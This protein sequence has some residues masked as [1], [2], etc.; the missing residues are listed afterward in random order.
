[1]G[2]TGGAWRAAGEWGTEGGADRGCEEV[3]GYLTFGV[4]P[5]QKS[6]N[7]HRH[8][9][10]LPVERSASRGLTDYSQVDLLDW[11]YRSVNFGAETIPGSPN[12]ICK[13]L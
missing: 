4:F 13:H 1:M 8:G 2:R 6:N 3:G 11:R 12:F 5:G 7:C 9:S 10:P